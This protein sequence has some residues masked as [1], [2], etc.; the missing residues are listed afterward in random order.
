MKALFSL[1]LFFGLNAFAAEDHVFM[2]CLTPPVKT[3]FGVKTYEARLIAN[4]RGVHSIQIFVNSGETRTRLPKLTVYFSN[5]R[6]DVSSWIDVETRKLVLT[7]RERAHST[8][9]GYLVINDGRESFELA[10]TCYH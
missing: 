4:D 6:A 7:Y 8:R 3:S 9:E 10:T 1:V 2:T 5:T